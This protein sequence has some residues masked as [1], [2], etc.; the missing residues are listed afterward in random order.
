MCFP[1]SNLPLIISVASPTSSHP[2]AVFTC[3]VRLITCPP[4]PCT[5]RPFPQSISSHGLY[6]SKKHLSPNLSLSFSLS[7]LPIV[8]PPI[9]LCSSQWP[10][11]REIH[12]SNLAEAANTTKQERTRARCAHTHTRVRTHRN[13][14]ICPIQP[15]KARLRQAQYNS[16]DGKNWRAVIYYFPLI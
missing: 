10:P 8:S 4:F 5:V 12:H 6:S 13:T 11:S 2:S 3:T 7:I 9:P 14:H 15:R 16:R 1:P